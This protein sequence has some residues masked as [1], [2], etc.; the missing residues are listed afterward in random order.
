MF[1]NNANIGF[2]DQKICY[3]E[4]NYNLI[5]QKA[6]IIALSILCFTII[7]NNKFQNGLHLDKAYSIISFFRIFISL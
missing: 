5:K 7:K 4:Q 3:Y 1:I 2:H 6:R